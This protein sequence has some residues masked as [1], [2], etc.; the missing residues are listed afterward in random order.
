M[1]SL[2]ARDIRR[3]FAARHEA[4]LLDFVQGRCPAR[5]VAEVQ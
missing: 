4:A 1:A 3:S 5:R 2:F